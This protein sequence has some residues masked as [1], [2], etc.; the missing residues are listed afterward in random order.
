MFITKEIVS[1]IKPK[2]KAFSNEP[3]LVS[4]DIAVVKVS[5]ITFYIA[6]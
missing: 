1:N 4:K 2:A 3:L 6:T 5:C